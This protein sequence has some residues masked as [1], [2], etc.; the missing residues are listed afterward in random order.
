MKSKVMVVLSTEVDVG[1]PGY[2][3]LATSLATILA[4]T[5]VHV[6]RPL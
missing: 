4:T 3:G 6:V 1:I 2:R 5:N